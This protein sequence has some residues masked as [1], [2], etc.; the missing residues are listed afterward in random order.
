[1]R[2]AAIVCVLAAAC[3]GGGSSS[4][5]APDDAA[6]PPTPIR[7]AIPAPSPSPPAPPPPT[8]TIG[9]G[10]API[11]PA[12]VPLTLAPAVPALDPPLRVNRVWPIPGRPL[13]A[14]SGTA[15]GG[16]TLQLIDVDR[17]LI[18][19]S[20]TTCG[21]SAAH[22][23]GD[24]IICASAQGMA[25][26]NVDDGEVLWR[27]PRVLRAARDRWLL[28][29]EPDDPLRG[30]IID[31]QTGQVAL[32]VVAAKGE[33][34]EE[35]RQLCAVDD[36]F[37]LIAW[38][39][40]GLMRRLH[41]P[42]TRGPYSEARRVWSKPLGR[43]PSKIEPCDPI[44]LVEV[45]I[46]GAEE[47]IL[48]AINRK[49]GVALAGPGLAV[50]GWWSARAGTGI[51]TATA[52]GIQVRSRALEVKA[53]V[54]A[55]RSGGRLVAE[56]Q[57]LRLIRSVAGTMLLLDGKGVR[58]WLAAPV[59]NERAV[60]T[61][62]R[63]LGG[64]W[65]S[66]PYTAADHITLWDLPPRAAPVVDLPLPPPAPATVPEPPPQRLPKLLPRTPEAIRLA[67]AG[68]YAIGDIVLENARLYVITLES[69]PDAE[70]GAGLAVFDLATRTWLWHRD[71]LCG[72]AALPGVA[73]ADGVVVCSGQPNYPAH[74]VLRAVDRETG[75]DRWK[76]ELET[77][78]RVIGGGAAVVAQVGTRAVVVDAASG[79]KLWELDADNGHV[80][81]VAP[82]AVG[83]KSAV[84]SVERGP[85]GALV[86]ARDP[87]KGGA[88]VWSVQARSYVRRLLRT[89]DG[90]AALLASGE[91]V[92]LAAADGATATAGAWAADWLISD[93]ADLLVD[94]PRASEG[95]TIVRGFGLDGAEKVRSAVALTPPVDLSDLRGPGAP[96]AL[97]SVRGQARVLVVEP[98]RGR[99]E[100]V[101]ALPPDFVRGGV[102]SAMVGD[103]SVVGA[104]AAKPAGVYLFQ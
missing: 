1:V 88:P 26:V 38:S 30:A 101:W 94:F 64:S 96:L 51:E 8:R 32:E 6:P 73:V 46:P 80:P 27:S 29:R 18:R 86:V 42:R 41:V 72:R 82:I 23:T 58:A 19:W 56:W 37:D 2:W 81:R 60:L 104:V 62:S 90:V 102:F 79:R 7:Y 69:R 4:S 71:D 28:A 16:P 91:L 20:T 67:E 40:V 21:A 57:D 25:G 47:R 93:R 52:E 65:L 77:V 10:G 33:T 13:A 53:Q 75:A 3:G 68:T 39:D 5:D 85:T 89:R 100:A 97:V 74:G 12:P 43:P 78:D 98:G 63:I 34:L 95:V 59:W 70:R 36:G 92:T 11:Y 76:L 99:L 103:K 14:A 35:V 22:T 45:P 66:P 55:G 49:T 44:M 50:L 48:S 61:G 9:R 31:A 84:I 24:R 83:G 87:K 15:T 17:G 54:A